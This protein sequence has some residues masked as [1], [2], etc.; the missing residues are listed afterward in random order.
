MKRATRC[1]L[2]VVVLLS[3]VMAGCGGTPAP[4]RE[5]ETS[6]VVEATRELE[7]DEEASSKPAP[8]LPTG[9][10]A[11]TPAP[12]DAAGRSALPQVSSRPSR[13]IIKNAELRLLVGD[14]DIAI[15]RLTQ[16]V[17]DV[18]G[19]IISSRVWY[20]S[21]LGENY[22]YASVT[23]GVPVDRFETSMRRL[24]GVAVQVQDETASG[25]DV[26]DEYV[27]LDSRLDNLKATR[28]RI[29][30]FLD[31]AES[32]EESLRINEE[33]KKVEAEIETVQGRMNY[34]FD[35]AAY[36]TITVQLSP[37]LPEAPTPTPTPT[38]EPWRASAVA[39]D[40]GQTLVA[41]LRVLAEIT[42][43]FSVV[44]LPFILPPVALV[45]FVRFLIQRQRG[46]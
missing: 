17:G 6:V 5:P 35:R 39:R 44:F 13:L 2:F 37:E 18:N 1:V 20:E 45:V 19:Y 25:Q 10:M 46:T 9:T 7:P 8:A 38:P 16:I 4:T 23:M 29:R 12:A 22:K 43:W 11:A 32:V 41:I 26:T 28:D 42:I 14:T 30:E 27:D 33:L 36:S 3:F 15:D 21:W 40:A 24:R 34:L 31:Q